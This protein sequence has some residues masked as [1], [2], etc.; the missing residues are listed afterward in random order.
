MIENIKIKQLII[1]FKNK[2]KIFHLKLLMINSFNKIIF[3]YNQ[4]KI[5]LINLN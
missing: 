4:I 1:L 5:N 2:Y 3:L